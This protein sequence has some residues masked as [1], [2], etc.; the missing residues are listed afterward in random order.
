M[1]R[2]TLAVIGIAALS[3][4]VRLVLAMTAGIYQ[5][6]GIY[7]WQAGEPPGFYIHPPV[8]ALLIRAGLAVFGHH[9]GALRAGSLATGTVAIAAVWLVGRRMG[10]ARAG[11]W[12]AAL[13]ACTPLFV[14]V[15]V[16]T[17][18]DAPLIALWILFLWAA[19]RAATSG[20]AAWWALAGALLALGLYSK[21]MMVLAVPALGLAMLASRE[22]RPRLRRA[23]PWAVV[24]VGLAL[25]VPVFLWWDSHHGWPSVRYHL[26]S[27]HRFE[28]EARTAAIY[29]LAHMGII[30]PLLYLLVLWALGR[31]SVGG[32]RTRAGLWAAGFGLVPILFFLP[33]SVLTERS[34]I[35]AHWDAIGYAAG[36]VALALYLRERGV[37]GRRLRRRRRL[38]VVAMAMGLVTV[39]AIAVGTA[40]PA[41]PVRLGLRPVSDR[42]MGWGELAG[43]VERVR[44]NWPGAEPAII[45]DSFRSAVCLGFHLN[46]R[47][48]IYTLW[49]E[50]NFRYGLAEQLSRWG[51]DE[52]HLAEERQGQDALYVHE[53]R[54]SRR[55]GREDEPVHI[56][57]F[58]DQGDV[59]KVNDLYVEVA[60]RTVKHFGIFVCYGL[61]PKRIMTEPPDG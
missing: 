48:G 21:Y 56:Y 36:V 51:I 18:P 25:F 3:L 13:F 58:F 19:W 33:P 28:P 54:V 26:V 2:P 34:M 9:V 42:I 14:A 23:G 20:R 53:Y 57:R 49:H 1:K 46:T 27:R 6:E 60:G 47:Q 8:T 31:W 55:K 43:R 37:R 59:I 4:A 39:G 17:G 16:V 45:T 30:S 22:D 50:R 12:A 40:W 15:G 5:D 41:V 38:A 7:W 32:R 29:V 35:R 61:R 52:A 24:V 44:R 10:G 11:L